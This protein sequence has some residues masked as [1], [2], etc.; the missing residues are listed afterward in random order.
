[1][2]Q[3]RAIAAVA[4][5]A[6][7]LAMLT[8]CIPT[9]AVPTAAPSEADLQAFMQRQMDFA[10]LDTGLPDAQRPPNPAI[11]YIEMDEWATALSEC[12][13]E[14]GYDTYVASTDGGLTLGEYLRDDQ[15]SLDW[16]L[17]QAMHQ[18]NPAEFG[19]PS[20][21]QLEYLYDYNLKVLVPCLEAHGESVDFAPTRDE[22]AT[23]GS[24]YMGWNPYY[25]MQSPFH[26]DTSDRDRDIYES[27]PP[28]PVG[29]IFDGN[30][31]IQFY[32]GGE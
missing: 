6:C 10:W 8:G 12:M 4:A 31:D 1:M 3:I 11:V 30:R 9:R 22:A 17:C 29:E 15:E 5:A 14:R 16:Y 32:S 13:T 28:Y 2:H 20:S 19:L 23:V 26:P 18:S 24:D 7:A 27:C 25:F 21:D